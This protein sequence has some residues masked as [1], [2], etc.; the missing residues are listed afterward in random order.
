MDTAPPAGGSTPP[1]TE[2]QPSPYHIDYRHLPHIFEAIAE[3]APEAFRGTNREVHQY[4]N[5]LLFK[6]VTFTVVQE[7]RLERKVADHEPIVAETFT[8]CNT[9]TGARL[10]FPSFK[11]THA[12][13][14][15]PCAE[16]LPTPH[17]RWL[18]S[19]SGYWM[20]GRRRQELLGH[21]RI[22][23]A[24]FCVPRRVLHSFPNLHTWRVYQIDYLPGE[25]CM[26]YTGS[27][28]VPRTR[29]I[30]FFGPTRF[31]QTQLVL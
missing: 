20:P 22:A 9:A 27:N 31:E 14:D 4:A 5:S 8:L 23:D 13:D 17:V 6:H 12:E 24:R 26:D 10:P 25:I 30:V 29:T 19:S 2:W 1:A 11:V 7:D 18:A 16:P 3:L 21:V 28:Y 15:C